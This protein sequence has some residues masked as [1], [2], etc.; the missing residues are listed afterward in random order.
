MKKLLSVFLTAGILCA[1][2]IFVEA[3]S[4]PDN[5][6]PM[7]NT[8]PPRPPR[9]PN[10]ARDRSVMDKFDEE[11]GADQ[12]AAQSQ[13]PIALIR[14]ELKEKLK[15]SDDEKDNY[16][17]LAGDKRANIARMISSF[18][19]STSLVVDLSDPRCSDNPDFVLVSYFSFRYKEYG[20]SPWT[21]INLIEDNIA[22]GNKWQTLGFLAD[23]GEEVEF[24]KIDSRSEEVK[25]LW[26][27]REAEDMQ[28][29]T[30]Q[31]AELEK[32]IT[33][34]GLLLSS[35]MKYQAN[36]TYLV[37]TISYRMDGFYGVG[38]GFNWHNTDSLFVF[39]VVGVEEDRTVTIA[40]RKLLQ[41]IAPVLEDK[42]EKKEQN[43]K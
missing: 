36:H 25:T 2:A 39:K 9:G 10:A 23:L 31:R 34:G 15:L 33:A 35:K 32:G 4:T 16:K 30:L 43:G 17:K 24:G 13:R 41:K 7:P 27:F 20:E 5:P 22:A 18:S 11:D 42:K 8:R 40:W 37:R 28:E 19:C 3:Q 29:K 6:K 1:G 26:E 14:K 38:F 12:K 21:D